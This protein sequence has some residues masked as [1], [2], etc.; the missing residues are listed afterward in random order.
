MAP[1]RNRGN[2]KAQYERRKIRNADRDAA[3]RKSPEWKLDR[4]RK[5][6]K[7]Q[8]NLTIDDYEKLLAKQNGVCAICLQPEM[9]KTGNGDIKRLAIDHCHRTGRIRGLLCHGCNQGLGFFKDNPDSLSN[10]VMYLVDN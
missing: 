10:A 5:L 2:L 4:W 6:L 7:E 8:Y 3:I 1:N 9:Q